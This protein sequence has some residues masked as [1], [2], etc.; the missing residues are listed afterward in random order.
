MAALSGSVLTLL[1]LVATKVAAYCL[2]GEPEARPCDT[3]QG[4]GY[5]P[6]GDVPQEKAGADD[7]ELTAAVSKEAVKLEEAAS[8]TSRDAASLSTSGAGNDLQIPLLQ[9]A[10]G[11]ELGHAQRCHSA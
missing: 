2:V 7:D 1:I 4:T 9:D 8:T 3:C 5:Q 10:G 6:P 11:E